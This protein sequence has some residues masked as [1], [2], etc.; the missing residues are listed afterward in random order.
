[1][2]LRHIRYFLAI[3]E[4]RSFTRAAKRC[5]VAQ[6]SLTN[7]IHR[8]ERE[9]GD[10][11][12]VRCSGGR[13]RETLPTDLA[14]AIRPH[15]ELALASVQLAQEAAVGF[16]RV[17]SEAAKPRNGRAVI[18]DDKANSLNKNHQ[19]LCEALSTQQAAA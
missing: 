3:Y 6:P 9:V 10:R 18:G 11:L 2:E 12:F 17:Q 8:L 1:M 7:A 15:L 19:Q 4:E 5:G 13:R 16:L 14:L